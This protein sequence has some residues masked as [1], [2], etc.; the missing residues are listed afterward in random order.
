MILYYYLGSGSDSGM[1]MP[2]DA[3]TKAFRSILIQGL[4]AY[5]FK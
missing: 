1:P 2:L 3:L 4:D 5:D